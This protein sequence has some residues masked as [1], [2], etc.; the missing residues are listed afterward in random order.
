[1]VRDKGDSTQ[2]ITVRVGHLFVDICG[3]IGHYD[4]LFPKCLSQGK[5][6]QDRG[7]EY[8]SDRSTAYLEYH[9]LR[10]CQHLPVYE[11]LRI[12]YDCK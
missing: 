10:R 9:K 8:A 7:Y 1:M 12:R 3:S 11:F 4:I 6:M 5:D 2:E